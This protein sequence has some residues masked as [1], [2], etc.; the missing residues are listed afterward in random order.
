VAERAHTGKLLSRR[1][2]DV[3]EDDRMP[4][5]VLLLAFDGSSRTRQP[6]RKVA[7][8]SRREPVLVETNNQGER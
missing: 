5:A 8:P 1:Q 4:G 2:F 3:L 6:P 7:A